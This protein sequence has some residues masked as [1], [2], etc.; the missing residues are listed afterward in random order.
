MTT[1]ATKGII[2]GFEEDFERV[3][4]DMQSQQDVS[5]STFLKYWTSQ[6]MDCLF[7]NRFDPR[8]LLEAITHL[9]NKLLSYLTDLNR[10]E[11][12]RILALFF[13]L[14]VSLKQPAGFKKRIRITCEDA[15][16]IEDL[17]CLKDS[18]VSKLKSDANFVWRHLRQTNAIDFVEERH[19]YGPSML[20]SRGV[21][22]R[23][24]ISDK[25]KDL[26]DSKR[27]EQIS[28]IEDKLESDL[29]EVEEIYS[30]YDQMRRD[31]E[32]DAYNDSSVDVQSDG[33]LGEY[34]SQARAL[35][36]SFRS[37]VPISKSLDT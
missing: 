9:N 7:T 31:L 24:D 37:D 34:I 13:L 35:I 32:L 14:C 28:F 16:L 10:N 30:S 29:A 27:N 22:S 6:H 3:V 5:L 33:S 23:T 12:D 18:N 8:E 2:D 20:I 15:L 36:N 4:M 26:I 11:C 25:Y 19:I 17:C 1:K 21:R